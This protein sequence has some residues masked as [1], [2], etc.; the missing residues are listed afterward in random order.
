MGKEC[1]DM[2]FPPRREAGALS[3]YLANALSR[4]VAPLPQ[5]DSVAHQE[6]K[7]THQVVGGCWR[8]RLLGDKLLDVLTLHLFDKAVPM[9][10]PKAFDDAPVGCFG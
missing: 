4:I 9:L 6:M 7:H 3:L 2:L 1:F 5:I 10:S 8:V